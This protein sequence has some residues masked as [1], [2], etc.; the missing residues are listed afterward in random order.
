MDVQF[1]T[2]DDQEVLKSSTIC[3]FMDDESFQTLLNRGSVISRRKSEFLFD[4]GRPAKDLYVILEG[5]AQITRIEK[6]GSD[7]LIAVF[8]EGD[9]LAEIAALL[10]K[11]Y[12]AS[13]LAMT[14]V[15]AFS[16]N[17]AML[18][19]MLQSR[20][21]ILAATLGSLYAKLHEL[22]NEVEILKSRTLRERLAIFLLDNIAQEANP[23]VL[24][25]PF[26]KSLIA[27]RIGTSPEQLSR[28]FKELR[29]YG[30][31][32][33]GKFARIEDPQVLHDMLL[34]A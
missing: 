17:G 19:D 21:S 16:I 9:S 18:L 26:N 3:K 31:H 6:D 30:V 11:P 24:R 14:D 5:W 8:K 33:E 32:V 29:E 13:A 20:R 25:L 4:Q 12:P 28:T 7:T 15:R 22:V 2:T 34:R 10:E 27:A 1:L 23:T